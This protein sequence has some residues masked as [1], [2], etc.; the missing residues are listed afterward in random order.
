MGLAWVRNPVPGV[1]RA[2]ARGSGT[3][4]QAT[5]GRGPGSQSLLASRPAGVRR[6][7]VVKTAACS[8][9]Q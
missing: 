9:P 7:A 1:R 3:E 2:Q 4:S 5:G 8:L 6:A